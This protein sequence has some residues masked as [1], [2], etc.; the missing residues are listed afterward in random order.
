MSEINDQL[1]DLF[2]SMSEDE[3][4]ELS[5]ELGIERAVEEEV[6]PDKYHKQLDA[7][8]DF[9]KDQK[10][11]YD[12][13]KK[14]GKKIEYRIDPKRDAK[15]EVK[16]DHI[17]AT[18]D[19]L[20]RF[21]ASEDKKARKA[22]DTLQDL[23]EE[24]RRDRKIQILENEVTKLG[25]MTRAH[26]PGEGGRD[27][28][29]GIGQGGDGQTPGSGAVWLWD[30]DDVEIGTPLNG[31]YPPISNGAV[32]VY[33]STHNHWKAGAAGAGGAVTTAD[34]SLVAPLTPAG[35]PMTD[36]PP[37]PAEG[38]SSQQEANT[39]IMS[40]LV[41]LDGKIQG[42]DD[43]DIEMDGDLDFIG[44]STQSIR[45]Y[46]GGELDIK[47]GPDADSLVIVGQFTTAGLTL[48]SKTLAAQA[49]SSTTGAFSGAVTI[50]TL[51]TG[52]EAGVAINAAA[53][54]VSAQW[55]NVGVMLPQMNLM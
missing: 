51:T 50:H 6:D 43:N 41:D 5:E 21:I 22:Y 10:R 19:R 17:Q 15:K 27:L 55:L 35:T 8:S 37:I 30:L 54:S 44:T 31:T 24:E 53:G 25:Q 18:A 29:S 14:S 1:N 52:A 42:G 4:V 12:K 7:E 34:V 26:F 9:Y 20:G 38:I 33:D 49:V 28:V 11:R 39:Y 36:L 40:A 23:T 47:V 2:A 16:E 46:N 3:E 32:L 48:P 45:K 13:D